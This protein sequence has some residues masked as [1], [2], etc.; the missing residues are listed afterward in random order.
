MHLLSEVTWQ[1][2]AMN[3]QAMI[4]GRLST[5]VGVQDQVKTCAGSRFPPTEIQ[6][7]CETQKPACIM[8][9]LENA[10]AI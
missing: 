10:H 7:A 2:L 3:W 5:C 1:D 8:R 9:G 4:L 6:S